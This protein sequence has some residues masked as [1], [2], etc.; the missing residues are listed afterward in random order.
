MIIGIF[1]IIAGIWLT[2][3]AKRIVNQ[4][5]KELSAHWEIERNMIDHALIQID[6]QRR[7]SVERLEVMS[8]RFSR[9]EQSERDREES[10]LRDFKRMFYIQ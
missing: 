9:N 6:T 4:H 7:H 10:V 2:R 3:I 1:M 8:E 5:R